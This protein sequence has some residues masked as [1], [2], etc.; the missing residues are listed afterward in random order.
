MPPSDELGSEGSDTSSE[1]NL[2]SLGLTE[3]FDE[4]NGPN[5]CEEELID[6]ARAL[7]YGFN[8]HSEKYEEYKEQAFQSVAEG[9]RDL[10][11]RGRVYWEAAVSTNSGESRGLIL[12]GLYNLFRITSQAYDQWYFPLFVETMEIEQLADIG[13]HHTAVMRAASLFEHY[14]KDHPDLPNRD[15]STAWYANR[16]E[17]ADLISSEDRKLVHFVI[18]LRNDAGHQTWLKTKYDYGTF[19][20][21]SIAATKLVGDLMIQEAAKVD[22]SVLKRDS[23]QNLN[24]QELIEKI[25]TDFGWVYDGGRKKWRVIE[26]RSALERWMSWQER[27]Q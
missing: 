12:A 7:Y 15:K 16:A 17:D 19:S 23:G 4:G 13:Q 5:W 3:V 10:N 1:I 18:E 24:S 27:S 26:Q 21:G 14:F 9:D 2:D 22:E 8:I 20:L 25:E 11:Q 6:T